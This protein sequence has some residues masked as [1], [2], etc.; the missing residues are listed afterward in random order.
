[1]N[2]NR[3]TLKGDFSLANSWFKDN[4][5]GFLHRVVTGDEKW[6]FYNSKKIKYYAKPSQSLPSISTST[7]QPNIHASK[8]MLCIWDQKG[9]VY[10]ELL[11]PDDSITGDRYR[12]QL[13]CLSC[14]LKN[15]RN[16]SK[17]MIKLFFFIITLDLMSLKS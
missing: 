14:A 6:I 17:D 7:P 11:K 4:R 2:W 5:E 13:I 1:M 16:M 12:L 8:I 15:G 3:E 10:Y 9:L